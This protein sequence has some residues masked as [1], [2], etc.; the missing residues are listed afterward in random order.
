MSLR[1]FTT[2]AHATI[3]G[4]AALPGGG[5]AAS[6]GNGVEL[7]DAELAPTGVI[8]GEASGRV[9]ACDDNRVVCIDSRG[10]YAH[11]GARGGT[12]DKLDLAGLRCHAVATS[13]GFL[14]AGGDA[15]IVDVGGAR[16]RLALAGIS[17]ATGFRGG[18]AFATADGLVVVDASGEVVARSEPMRLTESPVAVAGDRIVAPSDDAVLVFDAAARVVAHIPVGVRNDALAAFAGGV[19]VRTADADAVGYWD[20]SGD[21]PRAVWTHASTT[22]LAEP[23]AAGGFAVLAT[24]DGPTAIYDATGPRATLPL[25]GYLRGAAA[26]GGGVALAVDDQP[27]ATWWRP[28]E[29]VLLPHDL[30]AAGVV[31]VRGA[32]ATFEGA[33]LYVWRLDRQGPEVPAPVACEYPLGVPLIVGGRRMTIASAGRHAIRAVTPAGKTEAMPPGLPWREPISPTDADAVVAR[34]VGRAFAEVAG[35]P[36]AFAD[37]RPDELVDLHGRAMFAA[38]SLSPALRE[39]ADATRTAFFDELAWRLGISARALVA[40]VRARKPRLV[41]PRPVVGYDYLGT[42]TTTGVVTVSDPCHLGKPSSLPGLALAKRLDVA[43][44]VWHAFARNAAGRDAD[45]TAEL[46]AVHDTGFDAYAGEL[47]TNIGVDA[48]CVGVFDK[49]CPRPNLDRGLLEEGI[50]SGLGAITWSGQG[51]GMYPL[52]TGSASGRVVKLRVVY[53]DDTP[54][55]DRLLAA[56]TAAA[57]PYR[58]SERFAV[59]DA[60]DHVKFGR[61]AVVRAG[62]D[63]KID[64]RFVDGMRTLVHAKR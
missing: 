63:G 8:R 39:L 23:R 20:L 15:A 55:V 56:P 42:F 35:E 64:V 50:V 7:F 12:L 57:R 51:D 32:I 33:A 61:G 43:D 54:E 46:A 30:A 17:G 26:F 49:A 25:A 22:L 19:L 21:A 48:G 4:V 40:A 9:I 29:T 58:A 44:G 53:L 31:G 10:W 28:D 27:H 5:L 2:L 62:A 24:Y 18:A 52:F 6:T 13:R 3:Y 47:V 14:A 36:Q 41:P 1:P 37:R 60:I 45:R 34:L 11:A 38:G 16:T 59:G